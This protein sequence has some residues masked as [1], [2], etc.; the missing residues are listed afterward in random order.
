MPGSGFHGLRAIAQVWALFQT[1]SEKA[2]RYRG[3]SQL[4]NNLTQPNAQFGTKSKTFADKNLLSVVVR[5]SV[6]I[7]FNILTLQEASQDNIS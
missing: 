2:S 3:R 4:P 1:I 7:F 5:G 6:I